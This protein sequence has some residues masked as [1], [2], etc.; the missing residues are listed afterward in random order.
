MTVIGILYDWLGFY[1]TSN[2]ILLDYILQ[3]GG[4][5]GFSKMSRLT[6]NIIWTYVI[7]V[8]LKEQNTTIFNHKADIYT[9]L[10]EK[11]KIRTYCG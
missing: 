7:Y 11:V 8:V 9:S 3:F 1:S 4:R 6:F 2:G 10:T 5:R